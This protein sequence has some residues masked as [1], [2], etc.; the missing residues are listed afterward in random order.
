M[1]GQNSKKIEKYMKIKTRLQIIVLISIVLVVSLGVVALL[2]IQQ[3]NRAEEERK[4]VEEV[5]EGVFKLNVVSQ[6]YER[7]PEKHVEAEWQLKHDDLTKTLV[8][9]ELDEPAKKAILT[10]MIKTHNSAKR[11]FI[12]LG[13]VDGNKELEDQL[14][15]QLE[16][17]LRKVVLDTNKLQET[18]L[19]GSE[20]L[21]DR[22][23][24]V[25]ATFVVTLIVVLL[26]TSFYI[27]RAVSRPIQKLID[28]IKFISIGDLQTEIEPKL[29]EAKDEIAEL[30]SQFE[31]MRQSIVSRTKQLEEVNTQLRWTYEELKT[32]DRLKDEFIS[33]ASHELRTPIVPILGCTYFIRK[34]KIDQEQAWDIVL[35]NARRLYRLA[36]DIL[37]VS[38]IESGDLNYIMEKVRINDIILEAVNSHKDLLSRDVSIDTNLDKD[39]EITVDKSRISQVLTNIIGNA[40][41]FTR[42]GIIKVETHVLPDRNKIEIMISD[43]GCGIPEDI[44][45]R[46]FGKF[47]T[48]KTGDQNNHGTGL[49][50]YI[51]KAIVTTHGGKISAYNNSD[52]G[53]TFTIVLPIDNISNRTDFI[54]QDIIQ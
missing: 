37:D 10:E 40:V 6:N 2:T 46:L 54:P 25:I 45:P 28:A 41:K 1:R 44:L 3:L 38:R 29:Q 11:I 42:K 17:E 20:E 14:H 12:E 35:R 52:G 26:G 15:N 33:I 22:A 30:A 31:W 49:G 4:F 34:G 51:S 18:I 47:V 32:K 9:A 43:T 21:R 16:A 27:N 7:S 13:Q 53:A 39:L 50:L 36:N 48:A 19:K 24:S 5:V 23:N 8:L